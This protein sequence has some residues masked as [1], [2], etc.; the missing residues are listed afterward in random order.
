MLVVL[1]RSKLVPSALTDGYPKM[2]EEM[3]E[4]AKTMPGFIDVKGFTSP[5][6]ERM[7]VVWWEDEV[8]LRAWR[9]AARHRVAQR[10]GREKWYEYYKIEVAEILRENAFTRKTT[11]ASEV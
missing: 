11:A 1:F 4:L 8:T 7:T 5:D 3:R 9:E 6:G 2:A 10:I